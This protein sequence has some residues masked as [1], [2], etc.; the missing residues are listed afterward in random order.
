MVHEERESLDED[1]NLEQHPQPATSNPGYMTDE[2]ST[3]NSYEMLVNFKLHSWRIFFSVFV[4]Q[5]TNL[6]I[7]TYTYHAAPS[8]LPP[9]GSKAEKKNYVVCLAAWLQFACPCTVVILSN[10]GMYVHGMYVYEMHFFC[11][12]YWHFS[13]PR[14]R[15]AQGVHVYSR[16]PGGAP[17]RVLWA[18]K[19]ARAGK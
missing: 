4:T 18:F 5:P 19:V 1:A 10:T 13:R 7:H 15:G 12:K 8:P 2:Q 6:D 3:S 17:W 14:L 11:I 16:H 9:G